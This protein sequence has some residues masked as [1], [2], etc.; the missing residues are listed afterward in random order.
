MN[1][2]L[3]IIE[4][5]H[6]IRAPEATSD[7][8]TSDENEIILNI[9]IKNNRCELINITTKVNGDDFG[10][11]SQALDELEKQTRRLHIDKIQWKKTDIIFAF[12]PVETF[13][14]VYLQVHRKLHIVLTKPIKHVND[15]AQRE[16]ILQWAHIDAQ[17]NEHYSLSKTNA[18]LLSQYYWK[19]IKLSAAT[20]VKSCEQCKQKKN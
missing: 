11:I 14:A 16:E 20:Y 9:K 13:K 2:K 17:T 5:D 4:S 12:I 19:Y 10:D 18:R 6:K 8:T 1:L 15:I 3:P 7:C